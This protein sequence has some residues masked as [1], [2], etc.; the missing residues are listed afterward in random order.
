VR[1]GGRGEGEVEAGRVRGRVRGRERGRGS[2][3]GQD[4]VWLVTYDTIRYSTIW[5]G[6]K[7]NKDEI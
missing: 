6:L 1:E 7:G 4:T 2:N 5:C 3:E